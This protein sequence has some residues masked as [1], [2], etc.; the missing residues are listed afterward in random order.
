MT[1]LINCDES[2]YDGASA[3]EQVDNKSKH[4]RKTPYRLIH[5]GGQEPAGCRRGQ[6][7]E[8]IFSR[9]D[10][11]MAVH[12]NTIE[13]VF[14]WA[15]VTTGKTLTAY[16]AVTTIFWLRAGLQSSPE[17]SPRNI[18]CRRQQ[19]ILACGLMDLQKTNQ[20]L[21]TQL[22]DLQ[23]QLETTKNTLRETQIRKVTS[24]VLARTRSFMSKVE[25]RQH[26]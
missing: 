12:T 6:W 23:A 21:H 10:I 2:Q 5:Y 15:G 25:M 7:R 8:E 3:V 24:P 17:G 11:S 19:E 26:P 22:E 9:G 1:F 18:I 14:S 13:L 16:R 4:T 20:D